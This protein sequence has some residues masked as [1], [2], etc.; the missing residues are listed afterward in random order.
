MGH[1]Q[2]AAAA[3]RI[4]TEDAERRPEGDIGS[5]PLL[6]ELLL[7]LWHRPTKP[8]SCLL[9]TKSSRDWQVGPPAPGQPRPEEQFLVDHDFS[10]LPCQGY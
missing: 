1:L 5:S 7:P 2:S 3:A 10:S 4:V 6:L 9:R 8:G